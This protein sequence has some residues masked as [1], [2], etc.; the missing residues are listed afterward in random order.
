MYHK[1]DANVTELVNCQNP[2]LFNVYLEDEKVG[3]DFC[4]LLSFERKLNKEEGILY[5]KFVIETP[6]LRKIEVFEERFVSRSN[7]HRWGTKYRIKSL[8]LTNK[9]SSAGKTICIFLLL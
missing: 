7:I 2:F 8:I 5:L 6:A 1:A 9:S 3:F 4:N